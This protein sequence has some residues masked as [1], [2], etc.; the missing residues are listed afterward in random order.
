MCCIGFW[1]GHGNGDKTIEQHGTAWHGRA[2]MER[3]VN[4]GATAE[5]SAGYEEKLEIVY[6]A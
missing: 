2:Y 4:L 5:L 3:E 1:I 6:H